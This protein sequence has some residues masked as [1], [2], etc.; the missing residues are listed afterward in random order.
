MT[1]KQ[2]R[3]IIV[4]ALAFLIPQILIWLGFGVWV[5]VSGGY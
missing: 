5:W 4:G 1:D 2:L 3:L